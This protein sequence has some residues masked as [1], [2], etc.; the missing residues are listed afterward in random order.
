MS[1]TAASRQ[2]I[3]MPED[4]LAAA[5]DALLDDAVG[6]G[7]EVGVQVAVIRNGHTLVDTAR[8]ASD[9]RTGA[10][11]DRDTLFLGRLHRQGGGVLSGARPHRTR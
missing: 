2:I 5:V 9:P 1:S 3:D 4:H 11:V 7:Q 8:G 10:P 6:S